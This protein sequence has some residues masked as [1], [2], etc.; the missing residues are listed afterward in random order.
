MQ[1]A[2]Q[3]TLP[4]W[5][6]DIELCTAHDVRRLEICPCSGMGLREQ[7]LELDGKHWHGRCAISQWGL[8]HIC[9]LPKEATKGLRLNDIGPIAMK[10]LLRSDRK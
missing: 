10:K 1:S 7:M 4:R 2:K 9:S 8:V 3:I 6:G 5:D